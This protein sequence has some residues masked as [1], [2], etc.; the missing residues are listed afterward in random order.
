MC[1]MEH[2]KISAPGLSAWLYAEFFSFLPAFFWNSRPGSDQITNANTF[3]CV[4]RGGALRRR[5]EMGVRGDIYICVKKNLYKLY[6]YK[7]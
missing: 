4:K 2:A 7:I 6:Q 5:I 3:E 1:M